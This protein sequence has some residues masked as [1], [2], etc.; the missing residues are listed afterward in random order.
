VLGRPIQA[1]AAYCAVVFLC[2][3]VL[4]AARVL[5]VAPHI[6][7]IAAV[8]LEAPIILSVSWVVSAWC[9]D[10]FRVREGAAPRIIMG[11]AAFA[12]MMVAEFGVSVAVFHHSLAEHLSGYRTVSGAIGFAAQFAFLWFPLLQARPLA[13]VRTVHTAIYLVMVAST[14]VVVY[15]AVSGARGAGLWVSLGLL[16][17]ESVVFVGNGLKCPLSAIA[18]RY[19]A[20]KGWLFDTF[21]PERITRHTFQVF[22][23]LIL[24]GFVLLGARWLAFG[25][26]SCWLWLC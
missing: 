5:I 1:G 13:A 7:E 4:G 24:L 23:P 8:L 19:G 9:V 11:T 14:F 2:G 10:R 25:G 3:F 26:C 15:S 16:T 21:L 20:G 18:V 17:V 6:G 12:L 22:A